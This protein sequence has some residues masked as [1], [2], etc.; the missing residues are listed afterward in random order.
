VRAME[1]VAAHHPNAR[2]VF[3]DTPR[4]RMAAAERTR[5][6]AA[7]L[8]LLGRQVLFTGWLSPEKWGSCLLEADV[9]LSFHPA[10]AE[11]RF[12]F[13]TRL[14]DYIW[15]GLP[16]IT[17]GG[18]V[19]SDLVTACGLGHVVTPGDVEG[20]AAALNALLDEAD[21]RGARRAAFQEVAGQ[22]TW[23]QVAR[24]LL[25]YCRQPRRAADTEQAI[26]DEGLRSEV[27]RARRQQIEAETA[28]RAADER[29]GDLAARLAESEARFQAAMDGRVM[30]LMTGLQR[31]LRSRRRPQN[32]G[33][34]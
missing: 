2:L 16:I 34:R 15:A 12:A 24:P 1:A 7:D 8:G 20:L 18:D 32:E 25:D 30:R 19:L 10:S 21:A 3:F 5:Q 4:L 17:A 26:P 27:A 9:G 13:R 33:K 11:T 22:F 23:E 31:T 6:L 29:A 28:R 14:L